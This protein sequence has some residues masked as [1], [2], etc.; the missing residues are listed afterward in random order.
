[1]SLV[2][3]LGQ[4]RKTTQDARNW[5]ER[6]EKMHQRA[7]FAPSCWAGQHG[8][9]PPLQQRPSGCRGNGAR[10]LRVA[11]QLVPS[12]AAQS[13]ATLGG[14][15]SLQDRLPLYIWEAG[16]GVGMQSPVPA[17]EPFV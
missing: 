4:M 16:R 7:C 8:P 5:L 6:A 12:G 13:P 1:M 2:G 10:L 9:H 3:V 15:W 14:P 11:E 17:M